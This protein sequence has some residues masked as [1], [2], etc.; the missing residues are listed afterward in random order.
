M[1]SFF[2]LAVLAAQDRSV[3]QRSFHG[4]G[5]AAVSVMGGQLS[6][7]PGG[8]AGRS[9]GSATFELFPLALLPLYREEKTSDAL[10]QQHIGTETRRGSHAPAAKPF[11]RAYGSLK[12][13]DVRV[14]EDVDEDGKPLI[15]AQGK[16][17]M[18]GTP[19]TLTGLD[20]GGSATL[21]G[22]TKDTNE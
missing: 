7:A 1:R 15:P 4:V 9:R 20:G 8:G 21:N 2:D 14:Q 12:P 10:T 6:L 16:L 18:D 17:M 22:V 5:D 19:L 3:R 11:F 13:L